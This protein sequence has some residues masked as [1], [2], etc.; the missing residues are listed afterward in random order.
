MCSASLPAQIV[1][2]NKH[3]DSCV[4]NPGVVSEQSVLDE[5]AGKVKASQTHEKVKMNQTHE[6]VKAKVNQTP[7]KVKAKVN[8]SP[9]KVE[10]IHTEE[11]VEESSS[12]SGTSG[13]RGKK[14]KL[15]R[16]DPSASVEGGTNCLK[17]SHHC[18]YLNNPIKEWGY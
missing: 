9:K 8:Q 7:E 6:K 18:E 10:V 11:K 5:M 2:F 14:R 3:V 17:T 16:D 1:P 4:S 12:L 13:Q 15:T